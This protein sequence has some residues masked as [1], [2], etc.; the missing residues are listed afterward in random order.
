MIL[1]SGVL[2]MNSSMSIIINMYAEIKMIVVFRIFNEH[3]KM[4]NSIKDIFYRLN[5]YVII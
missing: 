2:P 5:V 4:E 3:I 1:H